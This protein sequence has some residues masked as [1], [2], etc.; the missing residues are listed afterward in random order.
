MNETPNGTPA[1]PTPGTDAS[2]D[3]SNRGPEETR[4]PPADPPMASTE[5]VTLVGP[6]APGFLG[7]FTVLQKLGE[8]GMGAVYLA[9][10]VKLKRKVAIK[11]MKPEMSANALDRDRFVREAR[12]AAAVEHD[13]IV[14][15]LHIGEAPDGTPYIVMPFLKGESLDARLKREPSVPLGLIL[16]VAREV[17]DGLAAAHAAGLIHR[18]IKPGNVWLDGDLASNEPAKQVR[19]CKVLDFGLA[20]S[21]EKEDAQL[22][23]SGA[24]L[25]TPAFMAPEQ[26]R[27]ERVDPRADLFSLGA[28]LYR[29]VTGKLP[30]D[31]PTPMAVMI[32]LATEAPQP[33][34]E[35]APHLPPELAAL[36]ERLM[37]KDRGGRPQSAAEVAT[38]VRSLID[39]LKEKRSAPTVPTLSPVPEPISTSQPQLLL[40]DEEPEP[41]PA[42]AK[43][44]WLPRVL[45]A[46]ILV[47]VPLVLWQSGVIGGKKP[48]DEVK[49]PD[50][51][52]VPSTDGPK[53]KD[54][55]T[56]KD[57]PPKVDAD[58]AAAL[59]V[60]SL[61]GN[62]DVSINN[63]NRNITAAKDLPKEPFR[64][65]RVV[66]DGVPVRDADLAVFKDCRDVMYVGLPGTRVGD[67]GL[68]HFAGCKSL[69][70]LYLQNTKVGG[71]G[72]A[73]LKDCAEL[74]DLNL[75]Y[76][77]VTDADLV[78]LKRF[79]LLERLNLS[80]TKVTA[81]GVTDFAKSVPQCDIDWDW[82]IRKPTAD[83]DWMA[84]MWALTNPF[85]RGTVHLDGTAIKEV[86]DLPR[87]PFKVTS[88]ELTPK[89][90]GTELQLTPDAELAVFKGCKHI[91][92][93]YLVGTGIT[94]AGLAHFA[95][96]TELTNL[97]LSGTKVDDGSVAVI[98]RF[99]NLTDLIIGQ[100]DITE[101]GVEELANA[102]PGCR[103]Q[104]GYTVEPA[105]DA[106][107]KAAE[108][109]LSL[110]AKVYVNGTVWDGKGLPKGLFRL[111]GVNMFTQKKITDAGLANFKGCTNLRT[112]S[113]PSGDGDEVTATGLANFKDCKTLS[114]LFLV[115][116]RL[117]DADLASFKDCTNVKNLLISCPQVGN[118]GLAHFK[119]C[120][121]LTSL[122]IS[123]I[124]V[125][126][127]CIDTL[128]R[129]TKLK[130]LQAK[131][132]KLTADGVK[133]IQ[134]ALPGCRIEWDSG[135]IEPKEK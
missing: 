130:T 109:V 69:T 91:T 88:V 3:T 127:A 9:E 12:T 37:C 71:A 35:L 89:L 97:Y 53:K 28:T 78:H 13:N 54:E 132:T 59:F 4:N 125:S 73:A 43:R 93:V 42:R 63:E 117:R 87:K 58:R 103:I 47:L 40:A 39:K 41:A 76:A 81:V 52:T 131:K 72:L 79:T 34:R 129:F 85:A 99:T 116:P 29:M 31:G 44:S 61:G 120:A 115:S 32:A 20:R 75:S 126:D 119:D 38:T 21:V 16:K 134:K 6:G 110:D 121:N 123:G 48:T 113:L 10:D 83:P 133:A 30:F 14:P 86:K 108:Y 114:L 49:N 84:A 7:E 17:A 1:P 122:D 57:E 23:A 64:L 135:I 33:V 80:G 92:G 26:A 96:C 56:K 105:T 18:D 66:I 50:P 11:L 112:L 45:V 111:T 77:P 106:D 100:T 95:G 124:A 98:K 5:R 74:L 19:R 46:L 118:A 128:K 82:G 25:G 22:T 36:I 102:L 107:R 27:G 2:S 51:P 90:K 24:I 67:A 65:R 62:V 70:Y 68:A 94:N 8:G 60:L 15:I 101:K 55:P 104:Y